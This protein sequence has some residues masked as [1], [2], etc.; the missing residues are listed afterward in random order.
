MVK[1]VLNSGEMVLT[2][3]E[4]KLMVKVK[5]YPLQATKALRAGRGKAVPNLTPRH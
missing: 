2:G 4:I 3:E 1:C 5:V